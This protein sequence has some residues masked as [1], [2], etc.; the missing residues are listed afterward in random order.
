MHELLAVVGEG[1]PGSPLLHDDHKLCMLR[2]VIP[3]Q[4][5]CLSEDP[6]RAVSANGIAGLAAGSDA[7]LALT[8]PGT[9]IQDQVAGVNALSRTDHPLELVTPPETVFFREDCMSH[10]E[11]AGGLFL[12]GQCH[13]EALAS[14]C[15]PAIDDRPACAG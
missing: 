8:L 3:R 12:P 13:S 1:W 11:G 9:Q 2:E 6:L 4:P 14:S 15:A 5:E 7:Q 10:I